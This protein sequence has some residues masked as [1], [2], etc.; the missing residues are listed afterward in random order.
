MNISAPVSS[1]LA[2][3]EI[4]FHKLHRENWPK[5]HQN[6]WQCHHHQAADAFFSEVGLHVH[7]HAVCHAGFM[8]HAAHAGFMPHAATTC[9]GAS[10][11]TPPRGIFAQRSWHL[12]GHIWH[13][14][15]LDHQ[16]R[17]LRHR[18]PWQLRQLR[19]MHDRG[20]LGD[21]STAP[22]TSCADHLGARF[23]IPH[24]QDAYCELLLHRERL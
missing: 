2:R 4:S 19:E 3:C 13:V 11:A 12:Y 20:Q 5:K 24:T 8:P 1:L 15:L 23:R 16:R 14:V 9:D 21:V 22:P 6:G 10:T 18:R 7:C 17:H